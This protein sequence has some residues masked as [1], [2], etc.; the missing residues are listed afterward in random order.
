VESWRSADVRLSTYYS[1]EKIISSGSLWSAR[2][3][4]QNSADI[5]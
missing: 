2:K 4:S 3:T 1:P 5:G